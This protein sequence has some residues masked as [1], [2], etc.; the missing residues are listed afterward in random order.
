MI[1]RTL[2]LALVCLA[3]LRAY[4]EEN[5]VLVLTDEDMSN[6]TQIFPHLFIKYYVPWYT[7]DYKGANIAKN[8]LLSSKKLPKNF[9]QGILQVRE[10]LHSSLG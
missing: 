3:P 2:I 10:M 9:R 5:G 6:I 7:C 8:W 4:T 1:V